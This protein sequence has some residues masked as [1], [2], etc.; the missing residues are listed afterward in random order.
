[1]W[2]DVRAALKA[3]RLDLGL[4]RCEVAY[5]IG[6][7]WASLQRWEEGKNVPR[8]DVLIRWAVLLATWG[9]E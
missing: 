5:A 4:G 8:G 9:E 7:H 3:R 1:M 2:D 6:V